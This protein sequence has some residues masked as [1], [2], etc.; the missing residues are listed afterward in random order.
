MTCVYD[1]QT[2]IMIIMIAIHHSMTGL[3]TLTYFTAHKPNIIK[4]PHPTIH[5]ELAGH[6][7]KRHVFF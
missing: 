6:P 7:S 4:L 3:P 5:Q 2:I 1:D